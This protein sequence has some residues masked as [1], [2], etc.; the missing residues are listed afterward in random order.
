MHAPA[1]YRSPFLDVIEGLTTPTLTT[2]ATL[3]LPSDVFYRDA[4]LTAFIASHRFQD[5]GGN[6]LIVPNVPYENLYTVPDELLGAVHVF[7][8]RLAR[9]FKTVYGCGGVLVRQHNE[10]A[11]SQDVWH[12]HLHVILRFEGDEFYARLPQKIPTTPEERAR[13]AC[14]PTSRRRS[15]EPRA[16]VRGRAREP[17]WSWPRRAYGRVRPRARPALAA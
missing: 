4:R 12:Y 8:K 9:V 13:R 3:T 5:R 10:P 17:S 11:G 6:A 16:A 15:P 2:S 7:S 14:A 1:G